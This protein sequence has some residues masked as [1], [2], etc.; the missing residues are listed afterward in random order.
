VSRQLFQP[1]GNGENVFVSVASIARNI[2]FIGS[3]DSCRN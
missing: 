1:V 2:F 3:P